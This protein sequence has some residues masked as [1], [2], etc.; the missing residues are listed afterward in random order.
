MIRLNHLSTYARDPERAAAHLAALVGGS[1][2]PFGSLA[3]GWIC[4]LNAPSID[5][6]FIEFY[7]RAATLVNVG[8]HPKFADLA[9]G[10]RGSGTHVNLSVPRPRAELEAICA[11]RGLKCATGRANLLDVW[12]EEDL[13]VELVPY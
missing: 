1:T 7:P 10:A 11:A 12:L 13:L 8:G 2:R 6:E 4:F 9:D 3:G 5:A